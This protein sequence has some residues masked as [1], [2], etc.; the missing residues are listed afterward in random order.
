MFDNTGT[1]ANLHSFV[2]HFGGIDLTDF[3]LFSEFL[4]LYTKDYRPELLNELG[5][6]PYKYSCCYPLRLRLQVTGN[7]N[8]HAYMENC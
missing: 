7:A 4:R 5:I 3:Y 1:Y 2:Q 8:S 6:T